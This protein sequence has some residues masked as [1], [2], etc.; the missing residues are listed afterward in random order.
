CGRLVGCGHPSLADPRP[1][2]DPFVGGVDHPL[3]VVVGQHLRWG[4]AAPAADMG[5]PD[6]RAH[7]G[8]TS[9]SGCFALTS[10]PLSGTTR[11]TRPARSDLISLNSFIPPMR[12]MN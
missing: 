12:P 5:V 11:T 2:H 3:E 4:V 8:S 9:M 7:S 10:A 6:W 1:R